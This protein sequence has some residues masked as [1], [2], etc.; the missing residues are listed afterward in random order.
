MLRDIMRQTKIICT[1]GPSVDSDEKIRELILAG[2]DAARFNFSHGSYDEHKARMDRVKRISKELK[3]QIPLILD[4]KGPEIRVR[5]FENGSVILEEGQTFTLYASADVVGNK[6]GVSVTFPYMSE[7]VKAG[8]EILIDDGLVSMTVESIKGNDLICR[9]KNGGKIRQT[10]QGRISCSPQ[11]TGR[12]SRPAKRRF[13][14]SKFSDT[15][16]YR[17]F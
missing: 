16:F 10:G 5:D 1:M 15:G 14:R 17:F 12:K 13:L 8:D 9:V 7:D 3:Q 4:T 6:D 11:K 2:M